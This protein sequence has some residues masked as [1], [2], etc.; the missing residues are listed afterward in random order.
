[1]HNSVDP[2]GHELFS[3]FHIVAELLVVDACH[4]LQDGASYEWEYG[5]PYQVGHK[6]ERVDGGD[7][8]L[9]T[10]FL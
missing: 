10:G 7:L 5:E 2:D 3:F 1:M 6:M 8:S 9:N 4:P